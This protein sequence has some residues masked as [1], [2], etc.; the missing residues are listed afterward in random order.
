METSIGRIEAHVE[1]IQFDVTDL[2]QDMKT[3]LRE[4]RGSHAD[5]PHELRV[6]SKKAAAM[7]ATLEAVVTRPNSDCAAKAS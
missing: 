7:E 3:L 1:H 2:R 4:I 6:P 5:A